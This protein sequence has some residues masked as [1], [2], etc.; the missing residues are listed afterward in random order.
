[1][2]RKFVQEIEKKQKYKDKLHQEVEKAAG[3]VRGFYDEFNRR[4]R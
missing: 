2:T 4:D 1:M 3:K